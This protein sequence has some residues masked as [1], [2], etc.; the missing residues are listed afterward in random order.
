MYQRSDMDDRTAESAL[1]EI[2]HIEAS[3]ERIQRDV[4]EKLATTDRII[5]STD[6]WLMQFSSF[7]S[8]RSNGNVHP[9]A[10]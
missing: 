6:R 9:V 1:T 7:Q 5:K 4:R 3:L 2:R 8:E 10:G